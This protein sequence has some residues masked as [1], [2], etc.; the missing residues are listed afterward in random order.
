MLIAEFYHAGGEGATL[1]DKG[2]IG[3]VRGSVVIREPA[4]AR[5]PVGTTMKVRKARVGRKRTWRTW[6]VIAMIPPKAL[7]AHESQ[8]PAWQRTLGR[9]RKVSSAFSDR[10]Q[11][12]PWHILAGDTTHLH[13]R[14]SPV[15]TKR[16]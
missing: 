5:G 9:G 13:E 10:F 14:I 11:V 12:G 4:T 16:P 1:G 15:E 3:R 2:G 6:K 7:T 8:P